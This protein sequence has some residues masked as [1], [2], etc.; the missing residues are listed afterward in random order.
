MSHSNLY[1]KRQ[2]CDNNI[3]Q[4]MWQ[5]IN[6]LYMVYL[7]GVRNE[8]LRSM[9]HIFAAP[10]GYKLCVSRMVGFTSNLVSILVNW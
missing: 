4:S 3:A 10:T 1:L 8:K 6:I 9:R 7:R 2:T 5:I